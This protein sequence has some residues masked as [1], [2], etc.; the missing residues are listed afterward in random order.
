MSIVKLNA[1][2]QKLNYRAIRFL[3]SAPT[4]AEC[5]EDSGAEVAFA[6][7]SNAGKSSAINALTGNSKLARTSKTPGRTQLIN[8]FSLPEQQRLVDLPG[9][10]YAK[11]ARAMKD[12]WQ[13]HL[14]AYLEQ[15]Q[16]LRGL[17]LLMDIRQP[18]KEFDLHMLT[19]A[20]GA[21]LPVHCLLTKADKLKHGPAN[22]TR[23]AVE[24]ALREQGLDQEVTL[25]LFSSTR[26]TGIDTLERKLNEW[27]I[28]RT[29]PSAT[30][31]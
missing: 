14:A 12:E 19:W 5:P 27:L 17:V 13:R 16:C 7:R 18:L 26:K 9:Y 31:S 6:G 1:Q 15:R 28:S 11:V 23:F 20:V 25:Q 8:F 2:P 24:K 3:T 22:N 4:L 10:G 29:E 21:G 30:S